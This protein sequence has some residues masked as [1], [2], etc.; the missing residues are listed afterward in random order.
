MPKMYDGSID[1]VIK[2]LYSIKRQFMESIFFVQDNP[3]AK[4]YIEQTEKEIEALEYATKFINE[5]YDHAENLENLSKKLGVTENRTATEK[6]NEVL[7]RWY[8]DGWH[9]AT[10]AFIR[11][12]FDV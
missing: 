3:K 10:L 4:D 9:D 7:N 6:M 2:T 1:E 12:G 5:Y 11:R 8:N